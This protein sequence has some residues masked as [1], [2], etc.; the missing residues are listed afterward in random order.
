VAGGWNHGIR[1]N[2]LAQFIIYGKKAAIVL[3]MSV[4]LSV[5]LS[6]RD[7]VF[8]YACA[9]CHS[10][11]LSLALCHSLQ[12]VLSYIFCF[13]DHNIF[14]E[15]V[16]EYQEMSL[17]RQNNKLIKPTPPFLS[18]RRVCRKKISADIDRPHLTIWNVFP[19]FIPICWT[20]TSFT[21]I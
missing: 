16:S 21:D 19:Y 15:F 17:S 1:R 11:S 12:W 13:I 4:R 3:V 10:R 6:A 5:R 2:F 9:L 18:T 20:S 8:S 14:T 7:H